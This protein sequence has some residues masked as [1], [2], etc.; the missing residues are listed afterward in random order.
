LCWHQQE[1]DTVVPK[2]RRT[3]SRA[4]RRTAAA[5]GHRSL[6]NAVATCSRNAFCM[7]GSE[8]LGVRNTAGMGR[9][10]SA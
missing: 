2:G 6:Q 9:R 5:T 8:D 1:Q 3:H 4:G 7:H 10:A